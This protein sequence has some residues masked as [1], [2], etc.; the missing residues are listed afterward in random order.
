MRALG[1]VILSQDGFTLGD[2]FHLPPFSLQPFH[3]SLQQLFWTA[4]PDRSQ[5]F[6][7]RQVFKSI[8]AAVDTHEL[9]RPAIVGTHFIVR[10]RPALEIGRAK[11]QAVSCPAKRAT[12]YSPKQAV[13]RVVAHGREMVALGIE[14]GEPKPCAQAEA[15][16]KEF[17]GHLMGIV[18]NAGAQQRPGFYQSHCQTCLS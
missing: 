6:A 11:A 9:L 7:V 13:A 16:L 18:I 4:H 1:P 8:V 2:K 15:L 17:V 14:P 12:A 5:E 3:T 10:N